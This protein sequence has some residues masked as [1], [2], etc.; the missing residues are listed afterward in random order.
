MG[1]QRRF[2]FIAERELVE[3]AQLGS[4]EACDELV[5]R[6]RGAVLLVAQQVLRSPEV[7]QDVA[8]EAF[9]CAFSALHQLEDPAKFA[10][11]LYAITRNRARRVVTRERRSEATEDSQLERLMTAYV[12]QHADP[13]DEVLLTEMQAAVRSVLCDLPPEMQIV[14]QLFYYEQWT[15]TR[16]AEFLS[17]PLTTVKWRLHAGRTRLYR[18]LSALL[19]ENSDVR[20]R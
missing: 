12:G 18:H 5:Y 9:L 4:T 7:A 3:I 1:M 20:S 15:A 6:F 19:E 10:G 2:Q 13:L 11:W 17:L 16:I 14:L 8:Q